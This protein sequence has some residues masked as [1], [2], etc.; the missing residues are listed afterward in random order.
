M[1]DENQKT[2]YIQGL[3]PKIHVHTEMK[4]LFKPK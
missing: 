4:K 1:K 2:L 3:K